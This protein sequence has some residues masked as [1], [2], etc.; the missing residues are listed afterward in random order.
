MPSWHW[1]ER[2]VRHR[3]GEACSQSVEASNQSVGHRLFLST[4]LKGQFK[5]HHK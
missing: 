5:E 4:E 1:L 3:S 2:E